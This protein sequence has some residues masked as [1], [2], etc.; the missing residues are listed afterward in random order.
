MADE[1]HSLA[2]TI[3]F[4]PWSLGDTIIA[5]AALRELASSAALA[6]Q[7]KWQR[8]LRAALAEKPNLQLIPAD[9]SYT[10]RSRSHPLEFSRRND[11]EP[12]LG[13]SI[14]YSI[15]G[16]LRDYLAARKLFPGSR[17]RMTGWIRFF[18]RKNSIFD[19]P[20][21]SGL[22]PVKNRYHS[23]ADLLEIPFQTIESTYRR[24]QTAA[25]PNNLVVIHVGAQWRS[26]QY[27]HVKQLRQLLENAGRRVVITATDTDL[28][29]PEIV[30]ETVVYAENETLVELLQSAGQVVTNDSGPMH[31]A[32][33]L[34]CRTTVIA[35]TASIEEWLPP[36]TQ[37]I[38][39]KKTPKGYRQ[40]KEYM[41]DRIIEG[42]PDPATVATALCAGD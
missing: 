32:A 35:R 31:L 27:P 22:I 9:L 1:P 10:T 41:T 24:R 23:W 8:I 36:V 15:R 25:P 5:A 13:A 11:L 33:F 28:L 18:A 14:V 19:L 30:P 26:K 20:F 3:L 21:S 29:P 42:W 2:D 7:S 39:S 38:A 34:G 12:T 40:R 16:D 4:E 37:F 6:C 17:I